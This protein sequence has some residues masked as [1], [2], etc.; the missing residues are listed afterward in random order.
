MRYGKFKPLKLSNEKV[1]NSIVKISEFHS[2]IFYKLLKVN[3]KLLARSVTLS[4]L[5]GQKQELLRFINFLKTVFT[6]GNQPKK[7]N[8]TT[9]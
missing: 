2:F 1:K 8:P 5:I 6:C 9:N 3:A 4:K 7:R